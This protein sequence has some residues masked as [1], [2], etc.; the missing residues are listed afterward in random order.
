MSGSLPGTTMSYVRNHLAIVI[1]RTA[2]TI[3]VL[4]DKNDIV[5]YNESGINT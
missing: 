3:D 4:E 2:W 1:P 5:N